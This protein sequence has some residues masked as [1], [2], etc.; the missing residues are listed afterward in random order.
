MQKINHRLSSSMWVVFLLLPKLSF[1]GSSGISAEGILE[2]MVDVLTGSIAH[3]TAVLAIVCLGYLYLGANRIQ[4]EMF[5]RL[6]IAISI[7]FGGPA[8][9]DALV[10]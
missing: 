6:V 10:G 4:K 2:N 8:L 7:I 9:Y 1:A 5:Y 3:W